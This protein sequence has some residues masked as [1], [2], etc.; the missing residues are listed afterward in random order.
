MSSVYSF[1]A[2]SSLFGVEQVRTIYCGADYYVEDV[3]EELSYHPGEEAP[4]KQKLVQSSSP[5]Q[6]SL[7]LKTLE[8][9]HTVAS[10]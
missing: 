9:P 7:L 2:I 8:L 1:C 4:E 10:M 3:K 5:P 6:R